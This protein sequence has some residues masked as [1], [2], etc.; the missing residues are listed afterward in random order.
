[1]E[2]EVSSWNDDRLDELNRR[3][4]EGFVRVDD[5]F[6]RLEGEMKEGFVR[7]DDRF[8]RL[9]GEMKE[10]FAE[11][12]GEIR[13]LGERFDRLGERFDRL[14]HALMVAGVSFGIG[15]F[16]AFGGILAALI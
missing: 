1:M 15:M 10:G 9:E 4:D 11:V 6:V 12:R 7:V 14:T 2:N 5:R 8:V 16:A 3:M 13:F